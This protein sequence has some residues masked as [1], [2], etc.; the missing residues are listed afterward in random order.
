MQNNAE[1]SFIVFLISRIV[2][3]EGECSFLET[4]FDPIEA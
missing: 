1:S 3:L 4:A 2:M